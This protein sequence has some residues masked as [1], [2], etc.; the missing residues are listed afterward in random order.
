ME[1]C[2]TKQ[3]LLKA[4]A[5]IESAEGNGFH[6]CLAVFQMASAGQSLSDCRARYSDIWERAHAHDGRLDWGRFQRITK[7]NRFENGMLVPIE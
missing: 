4:I 2:I 7:R 5:D 3:E 1:F 6:H